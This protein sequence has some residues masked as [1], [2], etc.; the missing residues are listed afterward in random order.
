MAVVVLVGFP[1]VAVV[2]AKIATGAY[3][4]R[5]ALPATIGFGVL[6]AYFCGDL[7]GANLKVGYSIIAVLALGILSLYIR[8]F[9]DLQ[10]QPEIATPERLVPGQAPEWASL[11]VVMSS[12]HQYLF[13]SYYSEEPLT[14]RLVYLVGVEKDSVNKHM[15]AF[16]RWS[17]RVPKT[18]NIDNVDT[19]LTTRAPFL[20]FGLP[21]N[22]LTKRLQED[23]RRIRFLGKGLGQQPVFLVE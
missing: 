1:V 12:P 20:E 22:V 7:A 9:D 4:H 19:F 2:F 17:F 18:P 15:E 6:F 14:F 16:R 13:Y 11:P 10:N 8:E 21:S 23:G 5:Y 3:T